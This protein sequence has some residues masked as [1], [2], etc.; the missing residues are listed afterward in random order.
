MKDFHTDQGHAPAAKR[1]Y[2]PVINTSETVQ[3]RVNRMMAQN[4]QRLVQPKASPR[5]APQGNR[6][7]KKP[8]RKAPEANRLN[9]QAVYHKKASP[10]AKDAPLADSKLAELKK[11][12]AIEQ[13]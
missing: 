2:G 1:S 12:M 13:R 11:L 9:R 5:K 8:H 4:T 7:L 10:T 3:E 6:T